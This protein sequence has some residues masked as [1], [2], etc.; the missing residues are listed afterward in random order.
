MVDQVK[1]EGRSYLKRLPLST[2]W[3]PFMSVAK[4]RVDLR[5]CLTYLTGMTGSTTPSDGLCLT[6]PV[7]ALQERYLDAALDEASFSGWLP[8]SLE[9]A[10]VQAG[11]SSG[12]A[13]LAAP[14]GAIDLIDAWFCRAE[15]AMV[16]ALADCEPET[17][18]RAKAT[19]AVRVRLEALATHKESLRRGVLYLAAPN[20][21]ADGLRM[22]WRAAD[23]AWV[24]MGDTST[25][26]NYYSKRTILS[27]IHVATLGYFLQDDS[28]DHTKSWAFLDRRIGNVMEFEKAKAKINTALNKIPDPLGLLTRLRYGPQPRP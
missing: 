1:G 15:R 6:D 18:I 7:L 8:N 3:R 5:L 10:R 17:K 4:T 24:A 20:N 11:L 9:R 13:M 12:E 28:E 27:G 23:Q 22:A 25:D 16:R 26:F 14:R 21:A 2:T 19:L